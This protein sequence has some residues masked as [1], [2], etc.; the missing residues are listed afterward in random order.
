MADNK[1]KKVDFSSGL[2]AAAE[3]LRPK[4]DEIVTVMVGGVP[5]PI[6]R[7][8]MDDAVGLGTNWIAKC[9][10]DVGRRS[11]GI[12]GQH[13]RACLHYRYQRISAGGCFGRYARPTNL[14]AAL[15]LGQLR[16]RAGDGVIDTDGDQPGCA[17]G[18]EDG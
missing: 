5:T 8:D 7:G 2:K 17:S 12:V 18:G 14:H 6:P 4:S 10:G 1:N 9:Y 15:D 3:K 16:S 11:G 13:D